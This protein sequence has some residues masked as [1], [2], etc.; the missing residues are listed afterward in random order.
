[1]IEVDFIAQVKCLAVEGLVQG[2]KG[3]L[4]FGD[5]FAFGGPGMALE[6]SA[7]EIGS[8]LPVFVGIGGGVDAD[9]TFTVFD[10]FKQGA[11]LIGGEE[12]FETNG[13]VEENG[14]VFGEVFG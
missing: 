6:N 2:M 1:M 12:V 11:A 10:E 8:F 5:P 4:D 14:V 9:E 13:V 7:D 3:R